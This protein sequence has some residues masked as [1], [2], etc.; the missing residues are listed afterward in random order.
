MKERGLVF[1]QKC[2]A[3]L[4]KYDQD[5][6]SLRTFQ[7]SFIEEL[8]VYSATLPKSGCIVNGKLWEQTKLELGIGEKESGLLPTFPTPTTADTWTDKLKSSQ[9][10]EGSM[11]SVN[12]SQA[13][14]MKEMFPTPTA[15]DYKDSVSVI[16]PSIGKTRGETV[17]NKIARLRM[18]ERKVFPTPT[19]GMHKQDV[20][21]QGEYAKRIQEKGHQ[22]S[23]PASIKLENHQ[24]N[25]GTLNSDW[26]EWLM[27][28]P[29][30]WT[31]LIGPE[32]QKES[33]E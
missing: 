30:G 3:L 16:P 4:A 24:N 32:S 19:S 13:V 20:N 11:H 7:C 6:Q 21:D 9:Q 31:D 15:R 17:A 18:E 33:Q 8:N 1:G 12:L 2:I 26:V 28:F 25:T 29:I 10:K 27:G 23:L 22:V 14:H 5:T